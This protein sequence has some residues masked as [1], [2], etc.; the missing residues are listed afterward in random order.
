MERSA[1]RERRFG[2][3]AAPEYDGPP[4][5]DFAALHPGYGRSNGYDDYGLSDVSLT[6]PVKRQSE[7]QFQRNTL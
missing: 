5:P 2:E 1:I 3:S 7:D 4:N 6:N